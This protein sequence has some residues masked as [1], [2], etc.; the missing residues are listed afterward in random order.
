MFIFDD[1]HY[2]AGSRQLKLF[3]VQANTLF[4]LSPTMT[5]EPERNS[6]A[7]WDERYRSGATGWDHGEV[8]PRY[9]LMPPSIQVQ[10]AGLSTSVVVQALTVGN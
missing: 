5:I 7:W 3:S 9:W 1:D 10:G 2:T 8:A 4:I 6:P